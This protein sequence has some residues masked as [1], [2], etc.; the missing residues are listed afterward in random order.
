MPANAPAFFFGQGTEI[1]VH[2]AHQFL[3][4]K[5]Y[6]IARKAGI[7]VKTAFVQS[8]L[9]GNDQDKGSDFSGID[10]LVQNHFHGGA[11][12]VG[13]HKTMQIVDDRIP[14]IALIVLGWEVNR[15][16]AIGVFTAGVLQGFGLDDLGDDFATVVLG[17]GGESQTKNTEDGQRYSHHK[18]FIKLG[19]LIDNKCYIKA[20]FD[21]HKEKKEGTED[22]KLDVD[23]GH[24]YLDQNSVYV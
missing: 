19:S 2:M 11:D 8:V 1:F 20:T 24:S 15:N 12:A 3:S 5:V 18:W 22:T 9:A 21:Y 6:P 23:E 4:C 14:L 16:S 13:A 7:A 17:K 10:A